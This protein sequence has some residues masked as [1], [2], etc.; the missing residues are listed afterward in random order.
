MAQGY[1]ILI[2]FHPETPD[3]EIENQINK[4]KDVISESKGEF[5]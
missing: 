5:L 4:T 3:D 1:E 2:V